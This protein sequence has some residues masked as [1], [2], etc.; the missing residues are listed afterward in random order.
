MAILTIDDLH[1]K[2][3]DKEVLKGVDIKI[4]QGEIHAL[5]GPN[6]SGKSTLSF[7]IMGHPRYEVTKGKVTI[8]GEDILEK[9]PD[10]RARSGLFLSF[11]YPSEIPGVSLSNF[12]RV[13]LNANR[14]EK[15]S[16][17][18]FRKLLYEKMDMLKMDHSFA[19]RYV[20]E[21]FSGGEKKRCEILQ[22]A[23]LR[24]KFALL[25]ETD[26][27]LDVDALKIVAQG[28][29][30]LVGPTLG[31]MIITHYQRIL[32]HIKPDRVHIL[33]NGKIVKSG[34]PELAM[35]IEEKGYDFLYKDQK[36][37]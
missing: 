12:L 28:V 20:N 18:D 32:H 3:E 30:S 27:G 35:E 6:G 4:K 25:D 22:M 2:V 10:E 15:I 11:Q 23:V 37:R 5:M 36:V 7:A 1:V 21:G 16:V 29:K 13:A 31:V 17:M 8:D 33:F 19:N 14:K 34:G 26:S 9:S 24:P